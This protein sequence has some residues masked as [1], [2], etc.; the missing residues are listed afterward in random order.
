MKSFFTIH[1]GEFL[2]GSFIEKKLKNLNVWIPSKDTGIDLLVTNTD[3]SKTLGI[4]VKFSKDYTVTHTT[5]NIRRGLSSYGWWAFGRDKIIRS[6]AD[7][8]I[9]VLHSFSEKNIQYIIIK[10][11]ELLERLE[12]IH[13]KEKRIQSYLWIT[14]R[15]KCWET[16]GL[17]RNDKILIAN[18]RF[19]SRE[20]D[21]TKYLN[22]WQSIKALRK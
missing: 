10:P 12:K 2:V 7:Y 4:Q 21:F 1:A 11:N 19:K 22:N 5:E 17:S 13:G 14:S 15:R 9:L 8:W 6:K 18:N 3:N 16:R 20:R